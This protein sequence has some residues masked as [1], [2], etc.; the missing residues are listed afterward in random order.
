M[1]MKKIIDLVVCLMM[2]VSGV[3][4][5]DQT[6]ELLPGCRYVVDIPDDMEYE[7][8]ET[9]ENGVETYFNSNLEMDCF[10][11][12]KSEAVN[13]G[14]AETLKETAKALAEKGWEAELRKVNGIKMVCV[15]MMD[16]ADGAPG[17]AYIFEDGDMM[18]EIDFWYATQEAADRTLQIMSSLREDIT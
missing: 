15:R 12:P 2:L 7:S 8:P 6:V 3:A 18:I 13:L 1:N 16:E 5:A 4:M 9:S 17:I 11:Y 10:C 14:M